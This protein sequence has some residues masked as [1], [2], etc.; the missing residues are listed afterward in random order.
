[1]R[2]RPDARRRRDPPEAAAASGAAVTWSRYA[3]A[4]ARGRARARRD[5]R[6]RRRPRC[7]VRRQRALAG[8][9]PISASRRSAPRP[10]ASIRR[11]TP[12]R[13]PSAIARSGARIVFCGDQ[14]QVD[15]LLERG[16][17]MP[18]IERMVVFDVKGLHTP[19]YADA[20]L[21]AFDDFAARGRAL[22]AERPARFGELLAARRPDD[23]ATVAFTSG[24]TGAG[25][26]FLLSQ[27]G[28][29]AL[30]GWSR[31]NIGLQRAGRGLLAAAAR[32]RDGAPLRRL[33]AARRG[34][35][36]QLRGVARNGPDRPGRSGAD[37]ARRDAEAARA[38]AGRHRAPDG[39]RRQVQA[40]LVPIGRCGRLTRP[41]D[42]RIAGRRGASLG[43]WLGRQPR[44]GRREAAGRARGR[45]LCG[46]GGSFVAPDSLRWFWALGVPVP[47]A[48]R[49]G[50]D[51]RDRDDAAGRARPRHGRRARSTRSSEIR[52]D[53]EE[54]L[55]RG[56][57]LAVGTLDGSKR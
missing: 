39:P 4:R 3:R 34:L 47:G 36:A 54:L 20:P 13:P 29:V 21:E 57:G 8:S 51:R 50:R 49:P 42:A 24:T 17:T 27:A 7:G 31:S 6:R 18:A 41:T 44:C 30:A 48:V 35:D 40:R 55:V 1:M 37:R 43:A 33:R 10:S 56:P 11:S 16:R 53:G 12:P 28:E 15:K 22:A 19:E 26:G 32:T 46:I 2:W 52:L 23:V 25:R 9:T 38:G 5:G 45:A 14:E